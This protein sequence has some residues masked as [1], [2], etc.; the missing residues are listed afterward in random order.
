MFLNVGISSAT[1]ALV[2]AL[3]LPLVPQTCSDKLIVTG[4]GG[5]GRNCKPDRR[6]S[7]ITGEVIPDIAVFFSFGFSLVNVDIDGMVVH[8][9][10]H[11]VNVM[12]MLFNVLSRMPDK[13]VP[14]VRCLIFQIAHPRF[15]LTGVEAVPV[16]R[17]NDVANFAVWIFSIVS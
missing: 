6:G 12:D 13:F 11:N 10:V 2:M 8:D 3:L 1:A 15:T 7:E 17:L 5:D 9:P 14:V 16:A 4:S